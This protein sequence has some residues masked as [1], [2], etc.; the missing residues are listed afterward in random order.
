MLICESC[1]LC[2]YREINDRISKTSTPSAKKCSLTSSQRI[3][4]KCHRHNEEMCF[5]FGSNHNFFLSFP[6]NNLS[7]QSVLKVIAQNDEK[8]ERT[9]FIIKQRTRKPICSQEK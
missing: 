2:E 3:Q 7:N 8:S 9:I 1:G 6:E 4:S 5:D